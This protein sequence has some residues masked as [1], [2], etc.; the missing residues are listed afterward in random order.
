MAAKRRK[1][2]SMDPAGT[3]RQKPIGTWIAQVCLLSVAGLMVGQCSS[4]KPA[5]VEAELKANKPVKITAGALQ[6]KKLEV[7][8]GNKDKVA[9]ENEDALGYTIEFV[10][11]GWPFVEPPQ[12]VL[13]PANGK[14]K[15][16]TVWDQTP[17]GAYT[18]RV[19]KPGLFAVEAEVQQADTPPDPP[20]VSVGD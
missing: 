19:R 9:W 5:A 18:Y 20:Q 17:K 3:R 15:V 13:V 10:F 16:F 8:R 4:P 7:S 12:P 2:D 11:E 14:S 1:L 6:P